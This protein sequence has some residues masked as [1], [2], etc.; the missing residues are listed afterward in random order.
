MADPYNNSVTYDKKW[1][2]KENQKALDLL[3]KKYFDMSECSPSCPVSWAP[4]VLA[5]MDL[6]DK[7]LGIAYNTSTLRAYRPQG[8]INEW[9]IVGPWKS[10]AS[11][12]RSHFLE[13]PPEW[14]KKKYSPMEKVERVISAFMHPIRYGLRCLRILKVNPILN[15]FKKPKLFLSQ[16]KEKYGSLEVYFSCP[17][18]YEE[19]VDKEIRKTEMK[20]AIKGAYYPVESFW[21]AKIS[22]HV[23]NEYSP[24]IVE[25]EKGISSYNNEPYINVSKTTY[26]QVMK[27]MGLD[28]KEIEIKAM[29]A[30]QKKANTP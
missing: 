4:E 20:L 17:D 24:D 26:R 11:A 21:N 28:L 12:F 3:D 22:Y 6:L 25:V 19:W 29:L 18:V 2:T 16:V 14:R 10:A 13:A 23:G 15:K 5:L 27:D 1:E 9:F 8:N 30:A 7:E